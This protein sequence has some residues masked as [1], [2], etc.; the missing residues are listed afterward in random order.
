MLSAVDYYSRIVRPTVDEFCGR[1]GDVRLAMLACMATLHVVDHVVQNRMT[2]TTKKEA[3]AADAEVMR[4]TNDLA[5]RHL[6]FAV[7]R[8]YGTASKHGRIGLQRKFQP[9]FDTGRATNRPRSFLSVSQFG[10]GFMGDKVGGITV[11]WS[12]HGHVNLTKALQALLPILEQE[13]PEIAS[14]K[15]EGDEGRPLDPPADPA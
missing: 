9:G 6:P 13:F 7:V 11:R 3:E 2:V 8:A 4:I 14:G 12:E 15:A 5:D 10:R 1:N